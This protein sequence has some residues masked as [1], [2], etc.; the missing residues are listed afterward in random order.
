MK[1]SVIPII[2]L[3]FS[4]L[5]FACAKDDGGKPN[6]TQLI[7]TPTPS[8]TV[9]ATE[10]VTEEPDTPSPTQEQTA[11]PTP[12]PTSTPRKYPLP[13]P[14]HPTAA[15]VEFENSNYAS[16]SYGGIDSLGRR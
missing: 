9:D 3:V 10:T 5:L 16:L 15:P 13:H 2:C 11:T 1:K 7:V 14:H 12:N 4:I 8:K 6:D